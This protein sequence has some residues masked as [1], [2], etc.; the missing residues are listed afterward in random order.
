MQDVKQ[1]ANEITMILSKQDEKNNGVF[2][3]SRTY[4]HINELV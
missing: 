1:I 3:T 4:R 2:F